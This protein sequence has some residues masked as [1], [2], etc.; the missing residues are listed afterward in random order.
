M[1]RHFS[2]IAL[3][4]PLSWCIPHN[5][6]SQTRS[7]TK[8]GY[9]IEQF[10]TA[11]GLP[12][13]QVMAVHEDQ[14]GFL[15][16]GTGNGLVRYDGYEFKT[17]RSNPKDSTS[18]SIVAVRSIQEDNEGNIW[19]GGS[20]EM[21]MGVSIFDRRT[22]RFKR[23]HGGIPDSLNAV[24]NGIRKIFID[25]AGN[26]WV[27]SSD[28]NFGDFMAK[29]GLR[30]I[31][32]SNIN[33]RYEESLVELTED[34]FKNYVNDI[35]EDHEGIIWFSGYG[36]WKYDPQ[37]QLFHHFNLP[38]NVLELSGRFVNT[39]FFNVHELSNEPGVLWLS[40]AGIGKYY[41]FYVE[42]ERFE[43]VDISHL[44]GTSNTSLFSR[45][46]GED[47]NGKLWLRLNGDLAFYDPDTKEISR[48]EQLRQIG[49]SE[50][51]IVDRYGTLWISTWNQGLFRISPVQYSFELFQPVTEKHGVI[52]ADQV[53]RFYS[54]SDSSTWFM[55]N[56]KLFV[57][58]KD[59]D[60]FVQFEHPEL[61]LLLQNSE[62]YN[63]INS[64]SK[65]NLW[66]SS[67]TDQRVV[68]VNPT[69][70]EYEWWGAGDKRDS[71]IAYS[72]PHGIYTDHKGR[73]WV[74]NWSAGIERIDVE[75]GFVTSYERLEEDPFSIAT[76]S[77]LR[78]YEAP[79]EPGILWVGTEGPL[80]RFD[81][82]SN[83]FQNIEDLDLY[84]VASMLEDSKGRF[85]VAT[86]G[87]GL[88]LLNRDDLSKKTYS[89]QDGLPSNTVSG[90]M[91]DDAGFLW[92]STE[93]GVSRFQP[94]EGVF[95]NFGQEDGLPYNLDR[96]W[97]YHKAVD[98]RMYYRSTSG[99]ITFDPSEVVVDLQE[100]IIQLSSLSINDEIQT[101]EGDSP[102]QRAFM[103][104]EAVTL[105]HNQNSLVIG[106]TAPGAREPESQRF[107]YRL[108][109]YEDQWVE[110]G[111]LRI[112]RYPNLAFRAISIR[113]E[114]HQRRRCAE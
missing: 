113:S 92:V 19:V 44:V 17:Y 2:F 86:L 8:D 87:Q 56:N 111:V 83:R 18:V 51:V 42:E 35:T 74:R 106:Y 32:S 104:S 26:T 108:V 97:G 112:A 30:R 4:L 16:L 40:T 54:I 49:S 46:L 90:I 55:S 69:T 57:R 66:L 93:N 101:V 70:K 27:G 38:D 61:T 94:D 114:S 80:S 82:E 99:Y 21:P 68:K 20:P 43:E 41:R 79:S 34:P 64:D 5:S 81:V 59:K 48:F 71:T 28:W 7:F 105:D 9:H 88:H 72:C 85:W 98:G 65:G 107:Q 1:V 62:N 73:I 60:V 23:I 3:L 52:P 53:G 33:D 75:T 47:A 100:P 31:D 6:H 11:D 39:F 67:C 50:D 102:L 77:T 25:E 22:E 96:E 24:L 109:N 58:E 78:I 29:G 45:V 103:L 91:E 12:S 36:L 110:A 10:T 15:W 95:I 63:V 76:N 14:F 89:T 84:W 37:S 13:N